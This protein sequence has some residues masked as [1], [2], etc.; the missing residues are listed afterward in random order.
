[1]QLVITLLYILFVLAAIV[2]IVVILLQEGKG[3][4]LT[5]ALGTSGQATFGVGASGINRFTGITAGVFL[6]AA[7]LIHILNRQVGQG[8]VAGDFGPAQQIAPPPSGQAQTPPMT[9]PP[10]GTLPPAGQTP[11]APSNP[12]PS[13]QAPTP[14]SNPPSQPPK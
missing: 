2:L 10:S 4:G 8:S 12:Q 3:G 14:P 1:M 6:V 5:D 7:L 9:L 11:T 13:G